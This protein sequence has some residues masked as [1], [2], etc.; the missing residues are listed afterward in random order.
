MIGRTLTILVQ[1]PAKD[2]Q[3]REDIPAHSYTKL[4]TQDTAPW[5]SSPRCR[6]RLRYGV[7][8]R[9]SAF[10]ILYFSFLMEQ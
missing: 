5:R 6:R 4:E 8:T 2:G 3:R 1:I 10:L 7:K 9:T